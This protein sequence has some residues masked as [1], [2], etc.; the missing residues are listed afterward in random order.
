[1]LLP[2]VR[3]RDASAGQ[4]ER[5]DAVPPTNIP[6]DKSKSEHAVSKRTQVKKAR[7]HGRFN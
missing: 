4:A 3:P 1:V 6:V 2:A 7:A 5:A